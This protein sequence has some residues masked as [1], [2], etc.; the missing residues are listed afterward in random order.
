M[1]RIELTI[2]VFGWIGSLAVILAYT[3]IS[4]NKLE[5][6]SISYQV[7]NLAGAV[8]LMLNTFYHGAYPSAFVNSI[9]L[10][11]AAI[12]LVRVS[13]RLKQD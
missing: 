6:K 12:A 5:S 10:L 7:L 3:L 9:W 2:N 8:G 11:I 1:T 13:D 4:F